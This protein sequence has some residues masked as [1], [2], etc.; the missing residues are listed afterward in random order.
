VQLRSRGRVRTAAFDV[1]VVA[2]APPQ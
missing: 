2:A 1:G